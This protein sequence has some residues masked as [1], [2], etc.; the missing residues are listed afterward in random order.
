[1]PV[2]S[3]ITMTAPAENA[4]ASD[5]TNLAYILSANF[6]GST[7]LAMLLGVQPEA[8]TVGEMRAPHVGVDDYLCSCGANIKK[9]GFWSDVSRLMA[10]RGIADFDITN[11]GLSI[12]DVENPYVHRLLNPLPRGPLFEAVRTTGLAISPVWPAHLRK[13]Q[14][15]NAAFAEVLREITGAKI[16]ID[17][18]KIALHLKF[19]LKS[20]D[21]KIKIIRLVR[22]GRAVTVSTM[23][24]G[25]KRDSRRETVAGAALSWRGNN[26][27]SER[28]LADLPT[29]Q[30]MFVKYEELCRQPE[31]TLRGICKFIGIDSRN[32]VLDFHAR[33]QHILGN[34]MRLKSGS[35]IRLDERW[36]KELSQEDLATFD[37]VA[38]DLNRKYGYA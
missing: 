25:F 10:K 24:H 2:D 18:S 20:K 33:Q 30:W 4:K 28:I 14:Q 7:L 23:G 11:A 27:A 32:I 26:E 17:S 12:H 37:E 8:T 22:D 3:S 35:D 5:A 15:R 29:S 16:V 1:M 34:E 38:G 19:L 6:S 21:L 31:E 36:R 9:C 13:I